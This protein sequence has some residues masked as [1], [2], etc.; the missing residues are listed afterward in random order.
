MA[1]DVAR[2]PYH[3]MTGKELRHARVSRLSAWNDDI[4]EFDRD[5]PGSYKVLYTI[6]WNFRFQDGSALTDGAHND[7]Y[8]YLKRSV[9]AWLCNKPGKLP[10]KFNNSEGI[11]QKLRVFLEWMEQS[12]RGE[13]DEID[14]EAASEFITWNI[15]RYTDE[16][17]ENFCDLD[18]EDGENREVHATTLASSLL[19]L[20]MIYDARNDL[21]ALGCKTPKGKH[22]FEHATRFSLMQSFARSSISGTPEIPDEKFIPIVNRCFE[23]LQASWVTPMVELMREVGKIAGNGESRRRDIK[24]YIRNNGSIFIEEYAV[25]PINIELDHVLFQAAKEF[26]NAAGIIIYAL[27]GLR[28]SELCGLQ[29]SPDDTRHEIAKIISVTRTFDDEFELFKVHGF[30][31][32]R[33]PKPRATSWLLGM[34]PIGS[35]YLPPPVIAV[36][37]LDKMYQNWRPAG[38]CLLV[39]V[40]AGQLRETYSA[41]VRTRQQ[42]FIQRIGHGPAATDTPITPRMWRK[43]FARYMYRT[44]S[45]L[46]PAIRNHLQH[47]SMA[48]TEKAYC[49]PPPGMLDLIRDARVQEAGDFITGLLT[50][51]RTIEGP[52]A[53]EVRQWANELD[54]RTGNLSNAQR[55]A[56]LKRSM[57]EGGVTIYD[58]T[59]GLCVFRGDGARCHQLRRSGLSGVIHL[60]PL[61]ENRIAD[62]CR[63]CVNFGVSPEHWDF[64]IDRRDRATAQLVELP[65]GEN[66]PL[67]RVYKRRVEVCEVVL[68]WIDQGGRFRGP[69]KACPAIDDH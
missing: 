38:G 62:I 2:P 3:K 10:R 30:I 59:F 23:I 8:N 67:Y 39:T 42:S 37:L 45:R 6:N 47:M 18:H 56:E 69:E 68:S 14:E 21:S 41:R 16:D 19:V 9:W 60:A 43:T 13:I 26:T 7:L 50:G 34:R 35:Q 51:D 11:K 53:K 20:E 25:R 44:N 61:F 52:V 54:C 63:N 27:A 5:T 46:L 1:S 17:I 4:W 15:R 29:G 57:A 64:W 55:K 28:Q 48:L 12:G 22:P 31:Y 36:N 40:R 58:S 24:Q 33:R 66:S 32:K 49:E 65:D